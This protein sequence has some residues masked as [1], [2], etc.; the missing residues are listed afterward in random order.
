MAQRLLARHC[1]PDRCLVSTAKRT[2]ETV[3]ALLDQNLVVSSQVE[4]ISELYLSSPDTI[5][6]TVQTDFINHASTPKHIMVLA[7][8]PGLE[9]LADT[10]SGSRTGAMPTCAVA[11]FSLEAEDFSVVHSANASLEF[12]TAPK[13]S[14]PER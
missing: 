12:F 3:A 4:Y 2:R 13:L 14:E 8:N 10:L 7:H 11:S 6:N 9:T 1:L 5:L